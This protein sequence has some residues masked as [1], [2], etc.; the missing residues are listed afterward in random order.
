M[1]S[2]IDRIGWLSAL[3]FFNTVVLCCCSIPAILT[4]PSPHAFLTGTFYVLCNIAQ[5]FLFSA[6]VG[7]ILL[8]VF[9]FIRSLIVKAALGLFF[10]ALAQIIC[11][12]NA[13]VFG[14]WHLYI[15]KTLLHLYLIGGTKV[16]EVH[17]TLYLWISLMTITFLFVSGLTVFFTYKIRHCFNGKC[18]LGVLLLIYVLA[19]SFFIFFCTQSNMRFLQYTIKI[20]YFYSLSI[21]NAAEQIGL[22]IFPEKTLPKKLQ[23]ILAGNKKLQYPLHP[24]HYHLPKKNLNVLLI[25]VDT[26]RYDMVN[27]INMPAVSAFSKTANLFLDNQSGGDCTRPGIFSLFY[28]IPATYWNSVRSERQGSILIQ[29]F[30]ANHYQ[31]GLYASAPLISPP[32]DQTVFATVK[33]LKLSTS[34]KTAIDRDKKMTEEMQAFLNHAAKNQKPFFGFLFYDAPHAYNSLSL[35]TPFYPTGYLNYFDIHNNTPVTPIYNLYKNSVHADDHLIKKILTT[36]KQDKL[37]KNTIIIIT[38]DH[39]Q[40]YNEYHND[41]WEHASGFSKYQMRTP[42]IIAWPGIKP[43]TVRYQTTHYDLAPTLL[44]RVLGVSNPESDYSVGDDFFSKKQQGPFLA[45]NYGYFALLTQNQAIIFYDSGL[46]RKT[47][48]TMKSLPDAKIT[49]ADFSSA[50][51]EMTRY[52]SVF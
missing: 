8:P 35:K 20:P 41:Y 39:G 33:N 38:S 24:L 31:L 44:R 14:F 36:L 1:K 45:S 28:S 49:P 9:L 2:R 4:D 7:V 3:V 25:V 42:M 22:A 34:G 10:V 12:M 46:Y 26:L 18:W 50:I 51:E 30:Q 40:E 47:T 19:Q 5:N 48:L 6:A 43:T 37:D 32:F 52:Y 13:K 29:A 23:S 11:F 15:N 27:P 17:D 21:S 16:F